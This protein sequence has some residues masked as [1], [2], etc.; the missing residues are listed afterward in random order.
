MVRHIV[1]WNF[2]EDF[3]EEEKEAFV[4]RANERFHAMVGQ[5]P[6]LRYADLKRNTMAGSNRELMLL[7]ELDTPEE[8]QGYQV[9]PLHV[10]VGTELMKPNTRERACFDYIM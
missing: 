9:H 4:A 6:G 3:P 5:V 1:M 10:A 7:T 2:R 8:L